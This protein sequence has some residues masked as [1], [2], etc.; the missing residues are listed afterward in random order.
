V[1]E[2]I[3]AC[4]GRIAHFHVTEPELSDLGSP[5]IDHAAVGRALRATGYQGWLSIEMRR[6]NHPLESIET[7]V[8]HVLECYLD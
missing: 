2:A 5:V 8:R 7:S 1:E 4:A 3:H 6:T